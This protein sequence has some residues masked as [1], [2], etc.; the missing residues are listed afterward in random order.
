MS[1]PTEIIEEF[2]TEEEFN[3]S[4]E[5]AVFYFALRL[6]NCN[7]RIKAIYDE[8]ANLVF[9]SGTFPNFYKQ[10]DYPIVRQV[11]NKYNCNTLYTKL[12]FNE[13]DGEAYC[14]CCSIFA[15]EAFSKNIV[16]HFVYATAGTIDDAYEELRLA[17]QS[18]N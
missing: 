2:L 1:T 8:E 13:E 4:K 11:L 14:N 17:L 18:Q 12:F 9:V 7:V 15:N 3:F 10:G 6:K 5:D 16:K